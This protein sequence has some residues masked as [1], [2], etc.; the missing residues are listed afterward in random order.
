MCETI[1]GRQCSFN[2]PAELRGHCWPQL[3]GQH[4]LRHCDLADK[5]RA[6]CPPTG[7]RNNS[8]SPAAHSFAILRAK[9]RT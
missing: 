4:S 6:G 9:L 8:C 2:S 7:E 5:L 1:F 3:P